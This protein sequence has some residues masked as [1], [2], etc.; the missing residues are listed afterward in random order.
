MGN[1]EAKCHHIL[2]ITCY[3]RATLLEVMQTG[4]QFGMVFLAFLKTNAD[5]FRKL[6]EPLCNHHNDNKN[7]E[8][9]E[10]NKVV[11]F[12]LLVDMSESVPKL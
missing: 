2:S 1:N 12:P 6:N 9:T 7:T 10:A 8:T 5:A 3:F 11:L 4:R